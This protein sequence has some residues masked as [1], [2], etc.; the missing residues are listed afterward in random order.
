MN[1]TKYVKDYSI[2]ELMIIAAARELKDGENVLVGIG[3]PIMAAMLAKR[4]HAPN[5]KIIFESGIIDSNPTYVPLSIGDPDS[6]TG[7][8]SIFDFFEVFALLL[9]PGHIDV[10]ILGGAQVDKYGNLNST[11]IGDYE[12][13]KV[14]LPGSGGA[15]AIASLAKRTI[16]IMP[17]EK[18]RFP[19]KVDFI[20]SPGYLNGMNSREESGIVR[21][22]PIAVITNLCVLRFDEKTK[23]MYLDTYHPGVSIKDIKA[24]TG[25]DLKISPNVKETEPP[26]EEEIEVLREIRETRI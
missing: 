9:Q 3:L 12:K 4:T 7:C 18:R 15:C 26:T 19:E 10:G 20:T 16:I 11:V 1:K 22:G 23:E 17:H 14:R 25:W 24:N 21:G 13:P 8:K 5:I 6:V 2:E